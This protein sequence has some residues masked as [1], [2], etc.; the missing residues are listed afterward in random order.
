M[1]L[2]IPG[3][4]H[5]TAEKDGKWSC[6]FPL[7]QASPLTSLARTDCEFKRDSFSMVLEDKGCT[8]GNRD[9]ASQHL[10]TYT[11][12][13]AQQKGSQLDQA[14]LRNSDSGGKKGL[15]ATLT[16]AWHELHLLQ[17]GR[18]QWSLETSQVNCKQQVALLRY[19]SV[20]LSL[21]FTP[22]ALQC[23]CHCRVKGP[24][25]F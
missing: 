3:L 25:F 21:Y 22:V 15:N 19:L 23:F 7:E 10:I 5:N 13:S 1:S 2:R 12:L 17:L 4:I 20:L 6:L 18:P 8:G 14:Y 11:S 24:L 16:M 9:P